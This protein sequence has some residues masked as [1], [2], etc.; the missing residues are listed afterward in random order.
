MNVNPNNEELPDYT[1]LYTELYDVVKC[2][3]A[4]KMDKARM[5]YVI[6]EMINVFSQDMYNPLLLYFYFSS[7]ENYLISH[8]TNNVIL[9]VAFGVSVNL[10][11][12]NLL[13]LGLCA[14]CHDL[15]MAEYTHLFQKNRKLS[16]SE[17][18]KIHRHPMKSVEAAHDFVS[19]D[20]LTAIKDIHEHVDGSGYPQGKS[21]AE[22]SFLAR[23]IS[24]CDVFEALTHQRNARKKMI[25][26]DAIKLIIKQKNKIFDGKV[27]NRFVDF[28]SIYPIG[29]LVYLNTGE[30]GMVIAGNYGYPTRCIARVLL[31][32]NREIDQ[33]DKYLDLHRDSM[34]YVSHPV[35]LNEESEIL[36]VLKPRGIIEPHIY[37]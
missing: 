9:A 14:L 1:G 25:P 31:T 6:R 17:A 36:E 29:S 20:V 32:S 18:R 27:V 16:D 33:S 12:E 11:K 4:S 26:Y 7:K 24:I 13:N 10:S 23:M 3:L 28:I 34:V 19:E 35:P 2:A 37:V 30:I 8:I 22:I 5:E 15:G 21:G